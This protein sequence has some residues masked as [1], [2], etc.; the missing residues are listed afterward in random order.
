MIAVTLLCTVR[1][2]M[3]TNDASISISSVSISVRFPY[4]ESCRRPIDGLNVD[5]FVFFR[6]SHKLIM[7]LMFVDAG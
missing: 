7:C 2:T 6:H 4:A 5:F 1:R 3:A